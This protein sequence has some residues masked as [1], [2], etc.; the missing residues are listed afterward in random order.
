MITNILLKENPKIEFQFLEKGFQ[1]VDENTKSNSGFYLYSSIKSVDLH[2]TWFP[3]LAKG[4]RTITWIFNGVPFFPDGESAKKA[5]II[6]HSKKIKL[7]I[8]LTNSQ[9]VN[10]AKRLK[11]ILENRQNEISS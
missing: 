1:L 5:N 2:K 6:I 8:W 7:G 4:L 10:Q 3:K 11:S 9:M